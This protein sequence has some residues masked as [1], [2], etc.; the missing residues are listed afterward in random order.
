M[1]FNAYYDE[2]SDKKLLKCEITQIVDGLPLAEVSLCNI[3]E[4]TDADKRALKTIGEL[5]LVDY[6]CGYVNKDLGTEVAQLQDDLQTNR[7][8]YDNA[9]SFWDE[10]KNTYASYLN[11]INKYTEE[12]ILLYEAFTTSPVFDAWIVQNI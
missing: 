1:I 9:N 2:L 6:Y 7:R 12:R 10:R 3:R 8:K 5:H 11:N 4:E